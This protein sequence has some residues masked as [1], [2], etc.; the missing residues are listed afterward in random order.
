M[1]AAQTAA[2]GAGVLIAG[3]AVFQ[4]ALALGM[5]LGDATWGGRAPTTN[6]AL[7]LSFR[8]VAAVSAVVLG[9]VAWLVLA[10]AGV[11]GAGPVGD[12]LL[13]WATRVIL[14]FLVLNTVANFAAPHPVERWVMGSVTL[15]TAVLVAVVAF[16]PAPASDSTEPATMSRACTIQLSDCQ[17]DHH[18]ELLAG[19]DVQEI[20][21]AGP[22]QLSS[23]AALEVF[24][25]EVMADH[26]DRYDLVGASVT[27][28]KDGEVWVSKGYGH[29][30]VAAG[31]PVEAD[32]TVFPT[33]SVAK[34]FTW[35]AVMQLVEQG[36]L[37]LDGEV[38]SYLSGFQIPDNFD[39]PVRVRHL[40]S[41]TAGFEDKPMSQA[42]VP[43]DLT[44]LETALIRDMPSQDWEPGRSA[45]Y[46]NYGGA[47][48]GYLVAEVSGMSWEDYIERNILQ[49]LD[50]TRTSGRQPTPEHLPDGMTKVYT[51]H[52]GEPIEA[53]YEIVSLAPQ[54]GM[55]ATSQDMANFMLAHLQ[56]G[57]VGDTRILQEATAQQMHSQLFTHD[58]RLAGNA[59]G[60]WESTENGQRV[61]SHGGDHNTSMTWLWLLPDHDLGIYVAYNS[62]RGG[63]ARA[64][65]WDTFLDYG[66]PADTTATFEPSEA[67][68]QDLDQFEGVYGFNRVSSTTPAKLSLLLGA[69]TV[70]AQ[71]GYLVT[72]LPGYGAQRWVGTGDDAFA[73]VDG[74]SRMVL[75][76][77]GEQ[78]FF[79]GPHMGPYSQFAAW[80]SIPWYNRGG[81]HAGLLAASLLLIASAL[82]LWPVLS[83]KRRRGNA[84][85]PA[86]AAVARWWAVA[87]S[88]LYLLFVV[89]LVA[90][91][92]DF[93]ALEYGASPL[94]MA[95]LVVGIL[96]TVLTVGAVVHAILAWRNS[97]WSVAGRIHYSLLTLAFVTLAW[98]LNHWNLLGFHV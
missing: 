94:L 42:V 56:G 43:D 84:I 92:L 98:Q 47:L 17:V 68:R 80:T 97:H 34:L 19:V 20:A 49:P 5:P 30:D 36:Q 2:V 91:L 53:D 3:V 59:H 11:V 22:S 63:E 85:R 44:D 87:T 70:S 4:L 72:D 73:S 28:V 41:H 52:E 8:P 45:A 67:P 33:A 57:R 39:E 90:S 50:M 88:G 93:V 65:L 10:R 14:G 29:A 37:D 40:L 78:V 55:V 48:A 25:D 15:V 12:S 21:Q 24:L 71:D 18:V 31:T 95:A 81:L 35:T 79:D 1:T 82:V 60:F 46:N 77:D 76:A 58:P 96:A 26:F 6:G 32:T 27:V 54:G 51:S 13:V 83:I 86:G 66:F 23:P 74:R 61:L 38:N 9:G 69:M 75:S 7:A 89:L 16:A 64:E 62:D